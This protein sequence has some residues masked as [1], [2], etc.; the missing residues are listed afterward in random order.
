MKSIGIAPARAL[1]AAGMLLAAI[2]TVTPAVASPGDGPGREPRGMGGPPPDRERP[3]RP[4][5]GPPPIAR[6]VPLDGP[7]VE[8]LSLTRDQR[9]RL[10]GIHE[11]ERRE[12]IPLVAAVELA[13]LDLEQAMR[14]E[15]P[16]R[17]AVDAAVERLHDAQGAL[18]RRRV[19][20]ALDQRAVLTAQQRRILDD[21]RPEPPR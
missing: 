16:Q 6:A 12:A 10:R 13:R 3:G 17:A 21:H 9:D 11:R 19:G 5:L 1:F 4:P 20:A 18:F 7:L 15:P 14:A 8:A 2:A